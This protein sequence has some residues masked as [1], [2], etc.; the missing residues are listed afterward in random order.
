[1]SQTYIGAPGN[2]NGVRINPKN[3]RTGGLL[4]VE[5]QSVSPVARLFSYFMGWTFNT[6]EGKETETDLS[7]SEGPQ[8]HREEGLEELQEGDG[9]VVHQDSANVCF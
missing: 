6:E 1:M 8:E 9:T 3:T 4:C 7:N 5:Q 2:E